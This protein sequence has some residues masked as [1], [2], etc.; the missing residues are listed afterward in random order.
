MGF[1]LIDLRPPANVLGKEVKA[2]GYTLKWHPQC[3][4]CGHGS[5]SHE[6][7]ACPAVKTMNKVRAHKGFPA[8]SIL[9]NGNV[10]VSFVAKVRDLGEEVKGLRGEVAALTK[11]VAKLEVG[12]SQGQGKGKKR[13]SDDS[14]SSPP[15]KKKAKKGGDDG[16]KKGGKKGKG[17]SGSDGKGKGKAKAN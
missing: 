12:P 3:R 4:L 6:P 5:D 16:G 15:K 2:G 10:D 9:D 14:A 8:I 17:A 7:S 13:K 1:M 11:R